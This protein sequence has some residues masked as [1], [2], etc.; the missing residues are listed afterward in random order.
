LRSLF[1]FD[2]HGDFSP[3]VFYVPD[4]T[5]RLV[6]SPPV[7]ISLDLHLRCLIS[8]SIFFP[9][10]APALFLCPPQSPTK[11]LV[12]FSLLIWPRFFFF[13][14]DSPPLFLHSSTVMVAGERKELPFPS[15]YFRPMACISPPPITHDP[16][17]PGFF[18]NSSP[19]DFLPPF[20]FP[21]LCIPPFIPGKFFEGPLFS[22]VATFSGFHSPPP[23]FPPQFGPCSPPSFPPGLP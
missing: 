8:W 5:P 16:A 13:F 9:F 1:T 21:P 18:R 7:K 19:P 6:G 10:F 2:S 3:L 14:F 15:G 23:Q 4:G 17:V 20:F 12:P 22:G 11:P